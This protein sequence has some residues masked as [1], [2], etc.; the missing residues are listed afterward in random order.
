MKELRRRGI[1]DA[2][3]ANAFAPECTR[4][5]SR[6]VR[7]DDKRRHLQTVRQLRTCVAASSGTASAEHF[8]QKSV[9]AGGDMFAAGFDG[10]LAEAHAE[11]AAGVERKALAWTRSVPP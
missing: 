6:D 4:N 8:A 1:S 10:A 7:R 3:A 9:N 2:V 11:L 5:L